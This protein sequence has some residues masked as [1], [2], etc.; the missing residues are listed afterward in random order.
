MDELAARASRT[1]RPCYTGFLSPAE[2]EWAFASSRRQ[3]VNVTFEGGYEDAERRMACFWDAEEPYAFPFQTLEVTW[4]HQSAPG[5]RDMLGSLMGLGLKRALIGDIV[6]LQDRGYVFADEQMA[7]HISQTL[8]SAGRIR[9]QIKLLDEPPALEP[10]KGTEMHDTVASL[11][12]DAVV[13]SG[14]H[15]SRTDAAELIAAGHVKLRH[16]PTER[17]DARVQEG[18]A[19]SV[20]GYGRLTVEQVG[21]PT[22]KGRLPV[23][24]MRYGVNR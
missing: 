8:T 22:K 23:T 3:R 15:L 6:I 24:L 20:R 18:D 12:L 14:F 13:A 9:L 10:P 16:L 4:P 7:E 19:V 5:H 17:P 11:R 21:N 2:A 1:G